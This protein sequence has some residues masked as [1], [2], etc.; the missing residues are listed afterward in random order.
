MNPIVKRRGKSFT[1][2]FVSVAIVLVFVATALAA[3]VTNEPAAPGAVLDE[4]VDDEIVVDEDPIL[5]EVI[6]EEPD[7]DEVIEE[8]IDVVIEEDPEEEPV[9]APEV[10]PG[11][12]LLSSQI[13][14]GADN[15][16]YDGQGMGRLYKSS[17]RY[18]SYDY[19][20]FYAYQSGTNY[21]SRPWGV[22]DLR[23]LAQYKGLTITSGS[24]QYWQYRRYMVTQL[25]FWTMKSIP[26]DKS[27]SSTEAEGWFKE[28]GGAGSVKIATGSYTG[29]SDNVRK[30]VLLSLTSGGI[31]ELNSRLASSKYNLAIGA[32]VSQ[33]YSGTYGYMYMG[34][35]RLKLTFSYTGAP[36]A[37]S[38]EIAVGN[39]LSGYGRSTSHYNYY[40]YVYLGSVYRGYATFDSNMLSKLLPHVGPGGDKIKGVYL[41]MNSDYYSGSPTVTVRH[42]ENDPKTTSWPTIYADAGDGTVYYTHT[43]A[44]AYPLEF[45]WDLGSDAMDDLKATL[46][47]SPNFFAVGFTST[48]YGRLVS[49]KL[50]V[51]WKLGNSPPVADAGPAT[52]GMAWVARYNGPPGN[53]YDYG[54]GV[55]ADSAGNAYVCGYSYGS[56]T[57]YD[58]ALVSY[59][60]A[61]NQRWVA[62]YNG[63]G[64]RYD[65]AYGC[66]VSG[67]RVYVA[68]Y[69][70]GSG[71]SY[72]YATVAYDTAGNQLWARRYHGGSSDYLR[73]MTVDSVGNVYVTGYS[74]RSPQYYNYVTIAYNSAGTQLWLKE[75]NGPG[76]RYDYAYGISASAG[77]IYVTGYSYGS[78]TSYDYATVAYNSAG[79]QLWAKRYNGPA[80]SSDYARAVASD[81]AGN[82][83]VQGYSYGSGTSYDYCTIAYSPTG[84]QLWLKRYHGGSTDYGY[85]VATDGAGNVYATGYSYTSGQYY[86][87][88][89]VAYNSAG[90]QLWVGTYNGPGNR[91]DYA[92]GIVTT[93]GNIYVTGYSYGTG[94]NYYDYATIAYD[95]AGNQL[96]VDRY[97][98]PGGRYDYARAITADAGGNVWV[99]GYSYGASGTNYDFATIKYAGG[100]YSGTEGSP[101]TFDGSAS[102]DPDGDPLQYRWD[103]ENDGIWDTAWSSS[104]TEDHTWGDD[105]TTDVALQVSDGFLTDTDTTSVTVSNVAPAVAVTGP[106]SVDEA[107]SF[108]ESGSATDPGSDDLTF[109]WSFE[110]G[111]TRTTI[112]YNGVGPD[113]PSSPG[114]TW[115]FSKAES[116][117]HTYGDNGV[118][119]VTLTVS[120]DDGLSTT[121]STTITV[122][123][124]APS[125]VPFGPFTGDEGTPQ[126][127]MASAT[128][129]GSDDLIFKWAFELSD[130]MSH[131]HYNDGSAADPA[132]S[133]AGT[134]PFRATDTATHTYGDNAVYNIVLT[135]TDDDGDSDSFTTTV[136]VRNLPPTVDV[137]A[138]LY[139]TFTL[140]VSGEKWHNVE[141]FI[142]DD[143]N[144]V[145]YAEVIRM[146]GDPDDQSVTLNKVRC[147]VT[148]PITVRV[149]WT[150]FD[151]PINGNVGGSNPVWV[152]MLIFDEIDYMTVSTETT[153]DHGFNYNHPSRWIWDVGEINQYLA[154][155]EIYFQGTAT[156]PGSDDLT[157]ISDWGD[158][159]ATESAT[160]YNNWVSP[161]PAKS[162]AGRWPIT[163]TDIK[164]H[165]YATPGNYVLK[166][167][168]LD[169]DGDETVLSVTIYLM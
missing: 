129:P 60:P 154:G 54:Y 142:Y 82:A 148:L 70:Y 77:N 21:E 28:I 23:D 84:T 127:F 119:T 164:T 88:A 120:D 65:Y 16:K 165:I 157:F 111:P 117:S 100:T 37:P 75:Y 68:G 78:G 85:A 76:N 66:A 15:D 130:T 63:P 59:D 126:D 159:S 2:R 156:D 40:N 115:P 139:I 106:S 61:G 92:Y 24:I 167:R 109:T 80:G 143:G 135:V 5:D 133:P 160:Y 123:N 131:S 74:Y 43:L 161:D 32:D 116:M 27:G 12:L 47:G 22:Y 98:E 94:S 140:R 138:Y 96:W 101:V 46:D 53:Q 67:G 26:Y 118:F 99:T 39:D 55:A 42:M 103:W 8:E 30:D 33:L 168:V 25:D 121:V 125:I 34:D 153:F 89:T 93:G 48:G 35:V 104:P 81:S 122:D 87:Y 18:Y 50:V 73:A 95:S 108:T 146:P 45:E 147:F 150:P 51:K 29:S 57:Y 113:P 163:F 69:S 137:S 97:H 136:T 162:P 64:N 79:T 144:V 62:R 6:E 169:D 4:I 3:T 141:M 71:T 14:I 158:G 9:I 128:D 20:Y 19:S 155:H 102:Y 149:M 7:I 44:G 110:L 31:A 83:Y 11:P 90:T 36:D 13:L 107:V 10:N 72:D 41:R 114:G 112:Y 166:L 38:G 17:T 86:N 152:T 151:D 134:W 132:K 91:Y 58:F 56:G 145:G 124:V 49:V 1:G 105:Y 52:T